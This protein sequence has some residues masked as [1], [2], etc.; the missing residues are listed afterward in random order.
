[1]SFPSINILPSFFATWPR[2][3]TKVSKRAKD[4]QP[5]GY[6][7]LAS[8]NYGIVY[9]SLDSTTIL[10]LN[11]KK[12]AL[13]DNNLFEEFKILDRV[14]CIAPDYVPVPSA[15]TR[16][17]G[18]LAIQMS[19]VGNAISKFFVS[20]S[21]AEP[22]KADEIALCILQSIHFILLINDRVKIEDLHEG[23]VCVQGRGADIRL[24]FI[25]VG[26]WCNYEP[27][28]TFAD[29]I[30]TYWID[31]VV[32]NTIK[33]F[34]DAEDDEEE[35]A[36]WLEVLTDCLSGGGG[37]EHSVF[38]QLMGIVKKS[39]KPRSGKNI[40]R[41]LLDTAALIQALIRDKGS[42]CEAR[43]EMLL[44]QITQAE[45]AARLRTRP[46]KHASMYST[47]KDKNPSRR[48]W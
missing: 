31:I 11:S 26:Q 12:G 24:R 15:L 39:V 46:S 29:E 14:G 37:A 33:V 43:G 20:G 38:T 21:E 5:P 7:Y 16:I 35:P 3:G 6:G 13:E 18:S 41:I 48:T 28:E 2:K 42:D 9:K 36:L 34:W 10:K 30:S 19:N 17:N 47:I 23:N 8:G 25:D 32:H 1:M 22:L 40:Y 45:Q 4:M 27:D 44:Q